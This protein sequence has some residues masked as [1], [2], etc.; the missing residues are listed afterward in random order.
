MH[1]A[2]NLSNRLGLAL[3]HC[4]AELTAQQWLLD[5]L[6]AGAAWAGDAAPAPGR[7]RSP[8]RPARRPLTRASIPASPASPTPIRQ[9]NLPC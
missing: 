7:R 5:L 6:A 3:D 2:F 1:P 8:L 9:E 4:L